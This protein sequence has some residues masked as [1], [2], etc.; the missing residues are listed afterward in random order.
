MKTLLVS[1]SRDL[2]LLF[3]W[4]VAL[5]V[6]GTAIL[7]VALAVCR[8]GRPP[9]HSRV[10]VWRAAV[11]ALLALPLLSTLTGMGVMPSVELPRNL[12][13][14]RIPVQVES[15]PTFDVDERWSVESQP[16]EDPRSVPVTNLPTVNRESLSGRVENVAAGL[17]PAG[18]AA[19][20]WLAG[21][22]VLVFRL[23]IGLLMLGGH[24]RSAL[25]VP[26][27]LLAWALRRLP[28]DGPRMTLRILRGGP[29]AVP[30]CWGLRH[31]TILLPVGS[32][33]WTKER[34]RAVVQ[35]EISHL[36]RKDTMFLIGTRLAVALHWFNPLAWIIQR[37][38]ARDAEEVCDEMVVEAGVSPQSY[39]RALVET[40]L[41][42]RRDRHSDVL[43]AMAD[44]GD[45][46]RRIERIL[47]RPANR[48]RSS[49]G[50][51][52]TV[53]VFLATAAATLVA[54]PPS[55]TASPAL[56]GAD[57]ARID[58]ISR[59]DVVDALIRALDDPAPEVRRSAVNSLRDIGEPAGLAA[60]EALLDDPEDDVRLAA[61]VVLGLRPASDNLVFP[62]SSP[63]PPREAVIDS[64]TTLVSSPDARSRLSA[65]RALGNLASSRSTPALVQTLDDEDWRVR[66]AA[67]NALGNI[68]DSAAIPG[69]LRAWPDPDDHVR[70]SIVSSLGEIGEILGAPPVIEALADDDRH[71]R[72][73]AAEALGKLG[74]AGTPPADTTSLPEARR[75]PPDA[76]RDRPDPTE[77]PRDLAAA[78]TTLLENPDPMLR[79]GATW[80]IGSL[81]P[82]TE[83]AEGL[84]KD[85]HHALIVGLS[86]PAPGVR[87]A[88]AC[89]LAEVGDER[90][91]EY[92]TLRT[93]DSEPEALRDA[94][95]WAIDRIG[96]R[97]E[98]SS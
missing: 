25:P 58:T 44:G 14:V 6:G 59:A 35:H 66:E 69:L 21:S 23:I 22:A 34:T 53:A 64:L 56:P 78:I 60:L 28:D 36:H 51:V 97:N 48:A 17:S 75:A 92:L 8:I 38:L 88:A 10:A 52:G 84:E 45:L 12:L 32:E 50:L 15:M 79:E 76:C 37:L 77:T 83:D 70:A 24:R 49:A 47:D 18:A 87:V 30:V 93:R 43:V 39:A 1:S 33:H 31:A 20:L 11:T 82:I 94:A 85:Y 46:E 19:G 74:R 62:S 90:A 65:A 71:V 5:A 81:S 68:G 95:R 86:D 29:L 26:P 13:Q 89:G 54:A 41:E 3:P 16:T 73:S 72:H 67:A 27:E 55:D 7:V 42:A 61:E 98:D 57:Q 9:A 96:A 80:K 40:A 2:A 91:L 63:S 4:L